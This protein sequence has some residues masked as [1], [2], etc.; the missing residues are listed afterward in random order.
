MIRCFGGSWNHARDRCQQR[1]NGISLLEDLLYQVISSDPLGTRE[2]ADFLSG[3][4]FLLKVSENLFLITRDS[5]ETS[6]WRFCFTPLPWTE[7]RRAGFFHLY[8]DNRRFEPHITMGSPSYHPLPPLTSDCLIKFTS[9]QE[10]TSTT[11][12]FFFF[13][14]ETSG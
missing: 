13:L 1:P 7:V 4:F 12:Y 5:I 14:V 6:E 11:P 9:C 10:Q 2:E 3:F 8:L